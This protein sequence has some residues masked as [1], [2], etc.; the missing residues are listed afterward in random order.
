AVERI[1]AFLSLMQAH[2]FDLVLQ[3][4][5]SGG[6][7]NPLALLFCGGQTAGYYAPGGFCPDDV[8]FL[9]YDDEGPERQRLLRLLEFIGAPAQ[10]D[11]LEFPVSADD[12]REV[13]AIEGC[14]ELRE[15]AYVCIHAGA[16]QPQRRWAPEQFAAVGDALASRGLAVVLTGTADER[17]IADDV[18]RRMQAQA[19]NLAGRTNLG[20]LAALLASSRLLVCND[21]GVS[22]LA[23]A[24][25][26]P[27][28]IVFTGS[29]PER[30]APADRDL[31][32]VLR[33]IGIDVDS[34]LREADAL[35]T[36]EAAHAA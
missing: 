14:A 25:R 13:S 26:V 1:P 6:I 32:R 16:R 5:G 24:L 11:A 35:L 36:T 7:T 33:G 34:V 17:A 20:S 22:H 27:S 4:H 30:W 8:L 10:G 15:R 2:A 19:L 9:P 12:R 29:E 23:D 31:H 18:E 21:T 3:L 28:V